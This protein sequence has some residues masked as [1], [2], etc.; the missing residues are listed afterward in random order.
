[1][2]RPSLMLCV[3][4][5]LAGC[6]SSEPPPVTDAGSPVDAVYADAGVDAPPPPDPVRATAPF[7]RY[8]DPLIGT[9]GLGY[10]TGSA[11][12]GPQRPFGLA[13]PGPDTSDARGA[14]I[15]YAHCAGYSHFDSHNAGFSQ[16]HM[17]GTGIV[18]YG[19][20]GFMPVVGMR[21]D[22]TRQTGYLQP[23]RHSREVVEVGY[24]RVTFDESEITTEVTATDH[25]ALYRVTFPAG[26][27]GHLLFDVGHTLS[28]VR[29]T[30]GAVG[31]DPAAGELTGRVHLEGGYSN[32][33][34][35]VVLHWVA[36]LSRPLTAAGTWHDGALR[37]D[38][39]TQTGAR[40]GAWVPVETT[41]AATVTVAIGLS[42]TDLD[43][44]RAN[45]QAEAADLDFDRVRRASVEAW[46]PLLGRVR[47]EARGE[48]ALRT[49]YTAVYHTLLMPT[50]LSDVDGSYR[51]VD[52]AVHRADG[53]RYYSDLSL[54]DTFR[55][56]HPWLTMVYPEA[57]RDSVRS[58]LAMGRVLGYF[59]R[60]PLGAGE[61]GGMLGDCGALM[62]ADTWLRGLRDYDVDAA[63]RIARQGAFATPTRREAMD[64]YLSLGYVPM[65]GRGS[66][67]SATLEYTYADGALAAMARGL[68]HTADAAALE[69]RSRGYRGLYDPAQGWLVGR[70][71]DGR[72]AQ[73]GRPEAWQ[74]FYAEGNPWQYLWYAPHDLDGLADLLGGRARF[75]ERLEEMFVRS[76][77][78]RRTPLPDPYYWHGNEPDIHAPFIPAYFG[79]GDT[80][81]RYVDWV[82]RTRYGDGPDGIPG[83][84]DA[85]TLSA[86]YTFAA[87]GVFPLAGT[88]VWLLAAPSV[89]AGEVDLPGGATLRVEAP[90][91]GTGS[92]RIRSVT[93]NGTPLERPRM[94]H[95]QIAQ[96]GTLRFDLAP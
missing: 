31:V 88:E 80:A 58:L 84:D 51:G 5:S 13:R 47:V 44:A 64:D 45:L 54:W 11:F 4:L 37:P 14:A 22:R 7:V 46:E 43:H 19:A 72:F 92:L 95:G 49:Y 25:V 81:S 35:G 34:G 83:N 74:D 61:T 60:W 17:H 59:P 90:S 32:R 89:T 67:A 85:G 79:D 55:T 6:G 8:V 12:P 29:V 26:S 77:A 87:L 69:T 96:G 56:E 78:A 41:E 82:R 71:R 76:M 70:H 53:W 23:F 62:V 28:E 40:V 42:L 68:G 9:G 65:E 91:A 86:W 21:P 36:R 93:W 24:Y 2:L 66:S 57:Q 63:W 33:I 10:G 39:R 16:L 3:S 1:M 27:D 48:A 20:L 30:D 52:R 75:L 15:V 73:V 94:T 50:L 18:D 38:A